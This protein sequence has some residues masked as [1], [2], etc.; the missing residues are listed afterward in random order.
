MLKAKTAATANIK[1]DISTKTSVTRS[2]IVRKTNKSPSARSLS[3]YGGCPGS[4][5]IPSRRPVTEKLLKTNDVPDPKI[6][7]RK[8]LQPATFGAS[9]GVTGLFNLISV[10]LQR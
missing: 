9:T 7:Y 2:M 4:I 6:Q 1:E 10:S 3:N 5:R 8:A